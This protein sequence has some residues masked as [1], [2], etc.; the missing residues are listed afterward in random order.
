VNGRVQAKR[1]VLRSLTIG[2]PGNQEIITNVAAVF[3]DDA[4]TGG[5]AFLGMNILGRYSI[6]IDEDANQIVLRRRN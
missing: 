4:A 5:F 6:T 1:G 2:E 3:I